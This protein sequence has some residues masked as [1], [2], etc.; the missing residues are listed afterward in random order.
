MKKCW[1][2]IRTTTVWH[3]YYE[4]FFKLHLIN[5]CLRNILSLL[6]ILYSNCISLP[7]QRPPLVHVLGWF[8]GFYPTSFPL[9]TVYRPK[10]KWRS[11]I[12][13]ISLQRLLTLLLSHT[14][15]HFIFMEEICFGYQPTL[16]GIIWSSWSSSPTSSRKPGG[17]W[18]NWSL[19]FKLWQHLM[20]RMGSIPPCAVW[21]CAWCAHLH[22]KSTGSYRSGLCLLSY[23]KA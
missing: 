12:I 10:G 7:L 22:Y 5:I 17:L 19:F 4:L 8:G 16:H 20:D 18:S 15:F 23:F 2:S 21:S 13:N 14:S 1:R 9:H 11:I 3:T 6:N